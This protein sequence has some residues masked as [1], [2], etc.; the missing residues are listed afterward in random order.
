MIV[1]CKMF[2][3]WKLIKNTTNDWKRKHNYKTLQVQLHHHLASTTTVRSL[4]P[5]TPDHVKHLF[6]IRSRFFPAYVCSVCVPF[7]FLLRFNQRHTTGKKNVCQTRHNIRRNIH[8]PNQHAK[9]NGQ[10]IVLNILDFGRIPTVTLAKWK[11]FGRWNTTR[12]SSNS[13]RTSRPNKKG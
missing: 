10:K 3:C 2:F 7:C 1:F 9:R 12:R 5:L 6:W 4:L 13:T 11:Q 8:V